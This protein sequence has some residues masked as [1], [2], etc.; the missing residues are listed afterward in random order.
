DYMEDTIEV[1]IR[2]GKQRAGKHLG[3]LIEGHNEDD[4]PYGFALPMD[5]K[6]IDISRLRER[7]QQCEIHHGERCDLST[8]GR[9]ILRSRPFWLIDTELMCL[10]PTTSAMQYLALSYVW[11]KTQAIRLTT[12]NLNDF[13]QHGVLGHPEYVSSLPRTIKDAIGL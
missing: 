6:W 13:Q 11:G 1:A 8:E 7:I 4:I 9:S 10:V 12:T 2:L 5:R 3:R